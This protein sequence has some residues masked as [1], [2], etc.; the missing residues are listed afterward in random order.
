VCGG[1][2][3]HL[4]RSLDAGAELEEVNAELDEL[5]KRGDE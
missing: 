2:R 3:T 5:M 1:C 4:E